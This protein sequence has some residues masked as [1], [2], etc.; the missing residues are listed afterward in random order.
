MTVFTGEQAQSH[1]EPEPAISLAS[2][3]TSPFQS[4]A[5][6]LPSPLS[7]RPRFSKHFTMALKP[8]PIP[9]T[10]ATGTRGPA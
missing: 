10:A 8:T 4:S 2:S 9:Q 5:P 3:R 6:S 1:G 7:L